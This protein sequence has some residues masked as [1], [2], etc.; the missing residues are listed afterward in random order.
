MCAIMD[1]M[2]TSEVFGDTKSP[3]GQKFREWLDNGPSFLVMGGNLADELNH[4]SRFRAWRS[5][6]IQY[7]KVKDFDRAKVDE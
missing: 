1:A 2:V 7:G 4:D 3:A 5:A 6:A